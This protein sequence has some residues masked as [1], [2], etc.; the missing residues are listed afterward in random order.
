MSGIYKEHGQKVIDAE[1][2]L[3][4]VWI[5]G[6][7]FAKDIKELDKN[8]INAV[9]TAAEIEFKYPENFK[10]RVLH[11]EDTFDQDIS[12]AF[13]PA[14][15][16]IE[17]NRKE[18]NVLVHCT[19]GISRSAALLI[20]YMMQKYNLTFDQALD[21]VRDRRPC[22]EPNGSFIKQLTEF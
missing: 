22:A 11:I 14:F 12:F 5:S 7:H 17:R 8:K 20:A 6:R 4:S 21:R 1:G 18:G 2:N 19:S 9:L 16:F 3:G 13:A 15:D 10:H